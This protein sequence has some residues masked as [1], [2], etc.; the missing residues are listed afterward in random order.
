MRFAQ[1]GRRHVVAP[2]FRAP[3]LRMQQRDVRKIEAYLERRLGGG[4]RIVA[5]SPLGADE[6]TVDV[7]GYG[8]GVPIRI[9]YERAGAARSLVLETIAP[10]PFGHEHMADRAQVLLWSYDAYNRLPRH[11]R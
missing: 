3:T 11:V 9:D 5:V 1:W 6:R 4:V 8:Y 7:K 2:L 10:G